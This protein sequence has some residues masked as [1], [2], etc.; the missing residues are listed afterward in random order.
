MKRREFALGVGGGLASLLAMPACAQ[1]PAEGKEYTRLQAA[2]AVGAPA[3]KV[4][5]VEFF[6]YWCPHCHAF[7]PALDAWVRKLPADVVFRRVPV[8]FNAPQEPYQ[9][10]FYALETMGQLEA[11]HRKV[12]NAIHID[13]LRLDKESELQKLAG[14]NGLDYTKLKDTMASFSVATKCNQAKQLA[15]AYKID[16]VPTLAV[17]GR[18]LTSVG[19]AGGHEQTLRVMDGLIQKARKG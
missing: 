19:L 2:V 3:G 1:E 15:N 7:E 11:M 13:R 6:G 18:F 10:L 8:A 16:G 12:F 17:Q 9:K 4:E 14:A 5:A